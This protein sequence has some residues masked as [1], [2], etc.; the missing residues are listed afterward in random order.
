MTTSTHTAKWLCLYELVGPVLE[1]IHLSDMGETY[2]QNDNDDNDD[3]DDGDGDD[4]DY[5]DDKDDQSI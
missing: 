2:T 1:V 4:D 3:D 5:D